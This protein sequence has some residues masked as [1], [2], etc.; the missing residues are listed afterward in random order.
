[1][2]SETLVETG[3]RA[4]QKPRVFVL[5]VDYPAAAHVNWL[6]N[7]LARLA[8]DGLDFSFEAWKLNSVA[9]RGPITEMI[10]REASESDI[11][12]VAA[13]A[14][15]RREP[16]VVE[17]LNSLSPWN[18]N[19]QRP[20]LLIGLFGDE[21]DQAAELDWM[22]GELLAFTRRTGRDYVWQWMEREV[23]CD[24]SWLAVSLQ[25]FSTRRQSAADHLLANPGWHSRVRVQAV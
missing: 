1:M 7:Q 6:R 15:D 22:V 9:G 8:Q 16:A 24:S 19:R 23:L 21:E 3:L 25:E 18:E 2:N 5:Y 12:V 14:L 10:A 4:G 17:W 20:G 11:L 13:T